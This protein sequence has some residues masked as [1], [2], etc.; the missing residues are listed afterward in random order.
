M[1]KTIVITSKREF[2]YQDI[3][4]EKY[5]YIPA[6]IGVEVLIKNAVQFNDGLSDENKIL[7]IVKYTRP[8][9]AKVKLK[10][11]E[12]SVCMFIARICTDR[13]ITNHFDIKA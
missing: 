4:S 5:Q 10:G 13:N 6:S 3:L 7:P 11:L 8:E 2:L 1:I 12:T 9:K